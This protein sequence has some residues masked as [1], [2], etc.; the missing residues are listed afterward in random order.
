M[1][2]GERLFQ[3][4]LALKQAN[5]RLSE[6]FGELTLDDDRFT[7]T[8]GINR[9][10]A[11]I[12][13][14]WDD[15]SRAMIARFREGARAWV[16]AMPAPPVE[17]VL[18]DA[19]PELPDDDASWAA[20]L[21]DVLVVACRGTGT[22]SSSACISPP[23]S[24]R[25]RPAASSRL[26]GV[27]PRPRR[28]AASRAICSANS[29]APRVVRGRTSGRS[30]ASRT[31]SGK[32]LLANDPHLLVQQPGAWIELHLR[33]PG[34]EARGVAAP[35]A[36]GIVLG[37][38]AH[39][40]WGATNV[41]GDVQDLYLER[42][43]DDGHRGAIRGRVGTAHD[44]PRADPRPRERRADRPRGARDPARADPR[45]LSHRP[46]PPGEA[47][48]RGL[49]RTSLGRRRA[50]HPPFDA[51]RRR[52][53]HDLRGLPR[54]RARARVSRPEP[55]LRRR[56]RHDRLPVHRPAPDPPGRRRHRSRFPAGPPTTSGM[57]SS[58]SRRCRSR[59]TPTAGTS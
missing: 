48:A 38:T 43:N 15:T 18:L 1:T 2:A 58:P 23:S 46:A 27:I 29:P 9:A 31:A 7:R 56:R 16:D 4:D 8:I 35:F 14:G 53:R 12:A 6:L 10:G 33:A 32:P 20:V 34:Y 40:A 13:A 45:L 44:P 37:T 42:L 49:V 55:R 21:G 30:P 36:P 11:T 52:E 19:Q 5:G 39:H 26:C 57:G 25:R 22:S 17:Y 41:C 24:A 50:Q 51:D 3:L 47:P 54:R 59:S 28:P